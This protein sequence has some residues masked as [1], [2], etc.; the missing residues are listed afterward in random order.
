MCKNCEVSMAL[1][2]KVPQARF[3]E[4]CIHKKA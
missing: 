2:P 1:S 4:I 3:N